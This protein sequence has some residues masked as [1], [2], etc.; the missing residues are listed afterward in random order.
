[1]T[2]TWFDTILDWGSDAYDWYNKNED[3]I[4]KVANFANNVYRAGSTSNARTDFRDNYAKIIEQVTAQDAAYQDDYRKW[5]EAQYAA[6]QS[7]AASRAAAARANQAAAR[8]AAQKAMR[9]KEKG[10]KELAQNFQPYLDASKMLAPEMAKNYKGFLD[11]TALLNN[12]LTPSVMKGMSE[13]QKPVWEVA[14]PESAY[15]IDAPKATSVSAE[16]L[17]RILEKA[18]GR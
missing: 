15:K 8:K 13:R 1:M 12:Y 11:S 18:R 9:Q 3:T 16:D 7:A 6:N 2:T 17:Q 14:V 5:Q 10:Y 4:G